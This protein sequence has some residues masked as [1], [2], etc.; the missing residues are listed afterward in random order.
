[1]QYGK[2]EPLPERV[3]LHAGPL[4]LVW[5]EGDLRY[6]KLGDVELLRR[7]Y[8]AIRDR[9]WGTAPNVM[10]NLV[11]EAGEDSFRISYDVENRLNE[12]HFTWRGEIMGAPDGTIRCVMDGVAQTSFMK[13]RIG[14]CVLHPDNIA[15][16]H[17]RVDHIDGSSED[18]VLPILFEPGQPLLPFAEMAGMAHEILPGVWAELRFEGDIFEME[19]QRNWTDASY[20]TFSTPLRIP[21]PVE[22]PAGT[23]ITQ[24]L[25][26]TL[27][28]TRP[29]AVAVTGQA[30]QLSFTV[31]PAVPAF[32]LPPLGLG[33]ASH[34]TLLNPTEVSRLRELNLGHLRVDLILG[35]PAYPSQLRR[36]ITEARALSIPL[37]VALLLPSSV[38]NAGRAD[39]EMAA[40]RGLLDELRPTVARW[41]VF[42]TPEIFRG[43]SPMREVLEPA[44]QHLAGY[45]AAPIVS[46]TNTDFIFMARNLPPL[47]LVDGL[48]FA[49][50]AEVH[51]FDN[52]SIVET[53]GTQG[54]AVRSG[55]ALAAG[56]PV[57]MSPVTLKMRHNP[58]A[59][60][61]IPPT[62]SGELPP[63]VDPRQMSLIVAGW[64]AG[65][66]RNLAQNGAAGITYFETTGWRGVMETAEGSPVPEKF[67]SIPGAVF[68]VYHVL[69]DVGEF[70]GG[71]VVAGGPSDA[72]AVNGLALRKDGRLRML[73]ANMTAEPKNVIVYGLP[74][75]VSARTLDASNAEAA[76]R[77]PETYRAAAGQRMAS[78][79][80]E[81]AL[82]LSPYAVARLDA[83][84]Q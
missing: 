54:Q 1:L 53:L 9:N 21:F 36:A 26:L 18:A 40:L 41:L 58:Y 59:T 45:S 62:P 83:R 32:E 24:A 6:V 64:T 39:A 50:T 80:G 2:D 10:S 84:L 78:V 77:A 55:R 48:T 73:V 31:D 44:R 47:A 22:V 79:A 7:I 46:G 27:Q 74:A 19:D 35:D 42:P 3:F 43:G 4:S 23:R 82:E 20:K 57:F 16:A 28:D 15:G 72:L 17:A 67:R 61:A 34:G 69:A 65:S 51:A 25:T 75:E 11:M 66:I 38:L 52:A 14:Y 29:A 60:G 8:V 71:E 5:E 33:V 63:Q 49:I 81:L 56:R 68:P 13:N 30:T 70:V 12:I 37:E 76:M